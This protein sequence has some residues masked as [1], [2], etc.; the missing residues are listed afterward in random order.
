M[1]VNTNTQTLND[2]SKKG[3]HTVGLMQRSY[4]S[5]NINKMCKCTRKIRF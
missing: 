4:N 5:R 1:N 2:E 3:R